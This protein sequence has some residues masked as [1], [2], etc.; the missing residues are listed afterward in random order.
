MPGPCWKDELIR[1]RPLEQGDLD[2]TH[3]WLHRDDISRA[4]GVRTPFTKEQQLHWFEGL[5]AAP[6][7]A[8]F[9]ICQVESGDHIGNVSLDTIDQRHKTARLSIFLAEPGHRGQG[10]G[11]RALNLLCHYAFETLDLRRLYCKTA[12]GE[13]KVLGFYERL[14]FRIEGTMREHEFIDGAYRDK[15]MLGL[16]RSEWVKLNVPVDCEPST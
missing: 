13:D 2:R 3:E 14:G 7:K 8:V 4:I 10:L 1:L 11:A 5:A 12:A 16:L 6:N 9:A 15:V